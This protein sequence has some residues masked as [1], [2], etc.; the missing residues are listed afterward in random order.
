MFKN[1]IGAFVRTVYML[2]GGMIEEFSDQ[3]EEK[4][5]TEAAEIAISSEAEWDNE[6]M[7][8]IA[9][10]LVGFGQRLIAKLDANDASFGNTSDP[11]S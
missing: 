11:A 6:G 8:R 2:G 7:R 4:A 10:F 5:A 1:K 9:N 3:A